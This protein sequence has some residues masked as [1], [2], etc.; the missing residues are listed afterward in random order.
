MTPPTKRARDTKNDTPTSTGRAYPS[1]T[2]MLDQRFAEQTNILQGMVHTSKLEI[3]STMNARFEEFR[4]NYTSL[5]EKVQVLEASVQR[6]TNMELVQRT[7]QAALS[8][9]NDELHLLRD[10]VAKHENALVSCELRIHGVPACDNENLIDLFYK[11]CASAKIAKP[12]ISSIRRLKPQRNN[13]ITDGA[14]LVKLASPQIR[15]DTLRLL[16][17]F[18]KS[19]KKQLSLKHVGFDST[20]P[21]YVN[22]QL[23]Q[24]NHKILNTAIRIKKHNNNIHSVF[25]RRGIVNIT[26][27]KNSAAIPIYTLHNC[28]SCQNL[29]LPFSILIPIMLPLSMPT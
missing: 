29:M 18:R 27:H 6:I 20:A 22:E 8:D 16:A 9:V 3:L 11:L 15:N 21:I 12:S 23:T 28:M 7:L 24:S 5:S 2:K 13:K 4:Q 10:K 26:L 14:I 19:T 17:E 1:L 25:T